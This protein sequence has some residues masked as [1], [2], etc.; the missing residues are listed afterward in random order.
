MSTRENSSS[1]GRTY[2]TIELLSLDMKR[3]FHFTG[4]AVSIKGVA[5][6]IYDAAF[7]RISPG[8]TPSTTPSMKGKSYF[9][10]FTEAQLS[11]TN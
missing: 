6:A 3:I 10:F 8:F 4:K 11:I 2:R 7:I 1:L 5:W 9:Q